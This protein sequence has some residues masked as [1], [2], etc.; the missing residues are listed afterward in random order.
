MIGKGKK[1]MKRNREH[2]TAEAAEAAVSSVSIE[3]TKQLK[4]ILSRRTK[5]LS[6]IW[7]LRAR[8]YKKNPFEHAQKI[9][10]KVCE[11]EEIK[12]SLCMLAL[13]F[14]HMMMLLIMMLAEGGL[15][16]KIKKKIRGLF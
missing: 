2:S 16:F 12:E 10:S 4:I 6:R 5:K 15:W 8:K 3:Q 14:I 9:C 13:L 1:S 7:I 11:W